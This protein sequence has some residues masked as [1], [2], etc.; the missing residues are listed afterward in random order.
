M[1]DVRNLGRYSLV[2]VSLQGQET[3]PLSGD[4][5]SPSTCATSMRVW[6]HVQGMLQSAHLVAMGTD[7][8][9]TFS[10]C[11]FNMADTVS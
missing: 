11:S 8:C 4:T 7:K 2:G 9:L 3:L 6:W 10:S 1:V 5:P